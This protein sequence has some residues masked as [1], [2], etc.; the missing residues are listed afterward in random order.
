M[1][2]SV[3]FNFPLLG[4]MSRLICSFLAGMETN[5]L[6]EGGKKHVVLNQLLR[7]QAL[8]TCSTSE[9]KKKMHSQL[10]K[11]EDSRNLIRNSTPPPPQES[12]KYVVDIQDVLY[13]H[14]TK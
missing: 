2:I 8:H 12:A 9:Q 5:L 6:K 10:S 11:A 1:T 14:L 4:I 7:Q 13:N 3:A